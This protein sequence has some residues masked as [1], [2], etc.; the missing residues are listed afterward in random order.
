MTDKSFFDDFVM[1]RMQM[2]YSMRK[3][4]MADDELTHSLQLEQE[5]TQALEAL[6][7]ATREAIE[8][9]VKHLYSQ[10]ADNETF[11]YVRGLKDGLLLYELLTEL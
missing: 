11:F 8:G 1:G 3:G 5:Y 9:F 6:P 7:D 2:H 4:D 10:A